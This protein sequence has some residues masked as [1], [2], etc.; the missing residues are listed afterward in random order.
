MLSHESVF[1]N[2]K[3]PSFYHFGGI[4]ISPPR[5]EDFLSQQLE[6]HPQLSAP[7]GVSSA[8]ETFLT[9]SHICSRAT[10]PQD[11]G[12]TKTW[13]SCPTGGQLCWVARFQN[14][15]QVCRGVSLQRWL[16]PSSTLA[17]PWSYFLLSTCF[18]E[19]HSLKYSLYANLPSVPLQGTQSAKSMLTT[20]VQHGFHFVIHLTP[21]SPRG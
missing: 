3:F 14:A 8:A 12:G 13:H 1:L 2:I 16:L 5:T 4:S 19:E 6:V 9:Q 21:H 7:A 15:P 18:S 11:W 20:K 17:S 10:G